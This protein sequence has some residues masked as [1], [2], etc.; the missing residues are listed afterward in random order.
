MLN[1]LNFE[2]AEPATCGYIVNMMLTAESTTCEAVDRKK[3][4]V[5]LDPED[6][7]DQPPA[8]AYEPIAFPWVS[9]RH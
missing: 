2:A 1:L 4:P 5:F 9:D 7:A 6:K 8:F 3:L